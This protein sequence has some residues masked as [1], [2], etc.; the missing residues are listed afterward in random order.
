MK[1][2][3]FGSMFAERTAE[4]EAQICGVCESVH[5]H[6]QELYLAENFFLSLPKTTQ[7]KIQPF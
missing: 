5:R 4:A 3:L 1:F 2:A 7:Q 6:G